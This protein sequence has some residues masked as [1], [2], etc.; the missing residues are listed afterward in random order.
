MMVEM[1][2]KLFHYQSFQFA[3]IHTE[4]KRREREINIETNMKRHIS[5][6]ALLCSHQ[7]FV[8]FCATS[9]QMWHSAAKDE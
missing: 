2:I 3:L 9:E 1:G 5:A 7:G 4:N 6:T 8:R